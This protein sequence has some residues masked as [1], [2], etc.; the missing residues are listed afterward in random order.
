M[1]RVAL[2]KLAAAPVSAA[3][4]TS[5]AQ[6]TAS[7]ASELGCSGN[8]FA[9]QVLRHSELNRLAPLVQHAQVRFS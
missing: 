6:T 2:S 1:Y 7:I 4:N 9:R 8:G 5:T 3:L